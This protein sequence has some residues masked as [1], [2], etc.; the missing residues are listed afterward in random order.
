MKRQFSFAP[1]NPK[2]ELA[3]VQLTVFCSSSRDAALK[4]N[5]EEVWKIIDCFRFICNFLWISTELK[6]LKLRSLSDDSTYLPN[7]VN[8]NA[9]INFWQSESPGI[10]LT[11]ETEDPHASVFLNKYILMRIHSVRFL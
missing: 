10:Y 3:A 9:Q 4:T 5:H 6:S 7:A 1:R 2:Q 11:S 8:I